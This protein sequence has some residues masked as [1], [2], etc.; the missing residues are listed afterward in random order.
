LDYMERETGIE[1][2]T[3]SLGRFYFPEIHN[4]F[5]I[6]PV[7][8]NS[9]HF[10]VLRSSHPSHDLHGTPLLSRF[11]YFYGQ[12]GHYEISCAPL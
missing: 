9:N 6:Q 12:Y 1:P 10:N 3:S 11:S 5:E 2:A 7:A 8:D 4:L